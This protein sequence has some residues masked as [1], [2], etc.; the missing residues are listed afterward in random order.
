MRCSTI[1]E[2]TIIAKNKITSWNTPID[3][4]FRLT[5]MTT[6][7]T[8]INPKR[9]ETKRRQAFLPIRS[10]FLTSML[11]D[12]ATLSSSIRFSRRETRHIQKQSSSTP[13]DT[14][15]TNRMSTDRGQKTLMPLFFFFSGKNFPKTTNFLVERK[16]STAGN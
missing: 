8:R 15:R 11:V 3:R 10:D 14:E 1:S 2:K 9:N 13:L 12:E 5:M 7:M 6:W 4:S 16:S